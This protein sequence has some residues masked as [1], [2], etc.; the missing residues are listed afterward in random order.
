[1][2]FWPCALLSGLLFVAGLTGFL[3]RRSG[4]I[5]GMSVA[6][7]VQGAL[8]L[9]LA[10]GAQYGQFD[11]QVAALL[12]LGLV[13]VQYIVGLVLWHDAAPGTNPGR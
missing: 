3:G 13:P 7:S 9:F 6:L 12:V 2:P 8:L 10:S 11:G 5:R 4:P 1:M